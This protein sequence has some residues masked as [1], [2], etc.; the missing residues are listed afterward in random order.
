MSHSPAEQENLLQAIHAAYEARNLDEARR[1]LQNNP[2]PINCSLL[3]NCKDEQYLQ[4]LL[5]N[6]FIDSP[7]NNN[8]T[9]P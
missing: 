5:D 9:P 2:S 7:Y 8:S 6:H 4:W 1:L 3:A